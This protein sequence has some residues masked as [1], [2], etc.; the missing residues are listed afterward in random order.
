MIVWMFPVVFRYFWYFVNKP[1]PY[2]TKSSEFQQL[3]YDSEIEDN[4]HGFVTMSAT[5]EKLNINT[6]KLIRI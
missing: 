2:P 3:H 4:W 1:L 5:I 6:M